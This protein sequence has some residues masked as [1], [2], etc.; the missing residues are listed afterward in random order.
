[1]KWHQANITWFFETFVLRPFLADY[2]LFAKSSV[3]S[4]TAITTHSAA[5]SS[6]F[7]EF[8]RANIMRSCN[9]TMVETKTRQWWAFVT[10]SSV[11][12]IISILLTNRSCEVQT[13]YL[14]SPTQREIP[15]FGI[16]VAVGMMHCPI[17]RRETPT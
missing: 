3:D 15:S 5:D 7:L 17:L 2:N 1:V 12:L 13:T 9:P 8:Q 4:S 11:E 6:E 10:N 14:Y 16:S